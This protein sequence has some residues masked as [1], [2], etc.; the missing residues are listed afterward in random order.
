MATPKRRMNAQNILSK[1]FLGFKS[2][3][4]TVDSEVKAKY[5]TNIVISIGWLYC[6]LL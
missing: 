1:S 6:K 2:P 3:N 5:I 4:P